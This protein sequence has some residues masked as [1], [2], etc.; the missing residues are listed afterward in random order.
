MSQKKYNWQL[1][2]NWKPEGG[3]AVFVSKDNDVK[4]AIADNSGDTPD[5]TDDG[6]LWVDRTYCVMINRK[7]AIVPVVSER[8]NEFHV[9]MRIHHAMQLAET[10]NL[11]VQFDPEMSEIGLDPGQ[12][13]ETRG[14][15]LVPRN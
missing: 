8:G 9:M 14:L 5:M 13:A 10:F 6:V 3:H 4:A 11:S 1:V 2:F 15:V 7:E 12:P